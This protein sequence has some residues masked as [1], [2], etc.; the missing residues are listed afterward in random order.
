MILGSEDP[1]ESIEDAIAFWKGIFEEAS[2]TE[3]T[4]MELYDEL[5]DQ[6]III[7]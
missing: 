2:L 3:G 5:I 7:L 4:T 6:V 1:W